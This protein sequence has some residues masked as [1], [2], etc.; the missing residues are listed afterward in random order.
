MASNTEALF[1]EFMFNSATTRIFITFSALIFVSF[2][3]LTYLFGKSFVTQIETQVLNNLSTRVQI[4]K[5]E[6]LESLQKGESVD[7]DLY[8][9]IDE[10]RTEFREML[11]PHGSIV[12][13]CPWPNDAFY[14][15]IEKIEGSRFWL[16]LKVAKPSWKDLFIQLI[17]EIA[18]SFLLLLF[19]CFL[20]AWLVSKFLM[21][22]LQSFAR[23]AQMVSDG[24]YEAPHLPD[25]RGDEVGVLAKTMMKM[26]VE[27]KKREAQLAESGVKLAHSARLASLGQ[28]GA[29]VAHEV[30]NPLMALSGHA[31]L[32]KEAT[33]LED[34]Q[35]T[36]ELIIRESDRC[37]QILQQM[38]RFSRS[39]LREKKAFIPREVIDS[40]LLLI[41]AEAKQRGVTVES[42]L[43]SQSLAYGN[44]LQIQQILL[45]LLLNALHA[46]ERGQ[47]V[48]LSCED[49][50]GDEIQ[51]SIQDHGSGI[52]R[53]LQNRIFEPFFTTKNHSG[54][55][56]L[57]LSLSLEIV[58]EQNGRIEFESSPETGTCFKLRLPT[59]KA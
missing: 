50:D 12:T 7:S 23:A 2:L 38:L 5:L 34:V 4:T 47:K 49:L 22:P 52:P 1:I 11:P 58:K 20:L 57:G 24:K 41:K 9:V 16:L 30:K 25:D 59:A 27:V 32:L 13:S 45:N 35:E 31:K 14:C 44:P 19:L 46:S 10:A 28:L 3:V 40:T 54:G 26:I 37:N 48:L 29:G 21:K 55:S 39:D 15:A 53:E 17:N 56:G 36:A 18:I 43:Q 8:E 51:V 33:R 6:N 42:S